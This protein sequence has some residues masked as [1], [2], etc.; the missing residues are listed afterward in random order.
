MS[1]GR[2]FPIPIIYNTPETGWAGGGGAS[3][4]FKTCPDSGT[5]NSQL[6]GGIAY[7]QEQQLLFFLYPKIFLPNNR[8]YLDGEIGYYKYSY[9]FY[10][11]GF[12][13]IDR[14][15]YHVD[16]PRIRLNY[17]HRV[18]GN[19]Y[20]G[21][22]I[23]YENYM[24]R[25]P[26]T[27]MVLHSMKVPGHNGSKL[28]RGSL[29]FLHDSRDHA[30]YPTRGQYI[31]GSMQWGL[32]WNESMM[33]NYFSYELDVRN[34]VPVA[35]DQTIACQLNLRGIH[36]NAPFQQMPFIGGDQY[37]KGFYLGRYRGSQV[38]SG[39]LEWRSILYKN[40]GLAA[41]LGA[42]V[43]GYKKHYLDINRV[44]RA[45]GLGIRYRLLDDER[46]NIRADYAVGVDGGYLYLGVAETF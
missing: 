5:R 38:L 19:T 23:F 18:H 33:P 43:M 29:L 36:G 41:Y 31:M 7:T 39:Q 26:D 34:Y 21:A 42:S 13:Q 10:G 24:I 17:F 45:A 32:P 2:L 15:L 44:M 3:Y 14:E 16:F 8:G 11:L 20:L 30:L 6:V 27:S 1:K 37:L 4:T 22:G 12:E 25:E 40:W 28:Y 35:P 46:L 9:Y